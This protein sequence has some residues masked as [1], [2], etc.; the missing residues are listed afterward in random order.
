MVRAVRRCDR[1][2]EQTPSPAGETPGT[3]PSSVFSPLVP[4]IRVIVA[5]S[6][7]ATSRSPPGSGASPQGES[8]SS[9]SVDTTSTDPLAGGRSA[10]G[11]GEA[12]GADAELAGGVGEPPVPADPPSS[13]AQAADSSRE[14]DASTAATP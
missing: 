11:L 10:D 13:V 9:V 3:V 1:E 4:S 7:E 12:A 2:T 14:A 8:R 6:R 5:S